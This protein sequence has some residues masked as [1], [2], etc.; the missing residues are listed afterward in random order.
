LA[1]GQAAHAD[2]A[3]PGVT[4]IRVTE[5]DFHI[6]APKTVLHGDLLLT[7]TNKGPDDHELTVVRASSTRLP[8]RTDGLTINEEAL[9][10]I[11]EPVLEPGAPG[12]VRELRLHLRAGRYVLF[13]N[14]AGHFRGGM[15]T[16]LV[17]R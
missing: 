14:M 9:Q 16:D 3:A 7:V 10:S 6:S 5:R 1:A 15:R 11:V 8:L 2:A 13:C 12:S 17:V 4:E